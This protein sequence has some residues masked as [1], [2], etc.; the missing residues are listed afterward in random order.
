[1]MSVI[2]GYGHK[3]CLLEVVCRWLECPSQ[4]L[5]L[6]VTIGRHN[7]TNIVSWQEFPPYAYK[8]LLQITLIV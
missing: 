5:A 8:N 7:R 3:L 2:D 4:L 1:M 6:L